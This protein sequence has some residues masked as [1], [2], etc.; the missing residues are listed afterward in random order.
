[1]V[2]KILLATAAVIGLS[3]AANA[4]QATPE[5]CRAYSATL[6]IRKENGI[7]VPQATLD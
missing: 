6:Q 7:T 2:K 3:G 4:Q 1:M 5:Q